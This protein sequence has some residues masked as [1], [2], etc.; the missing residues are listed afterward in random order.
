MVITLEGFGFG[1]AYKIF[2]FLYF[3]KILGVAFYLHIDRTLKTP[4]LR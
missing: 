3:Q 1:T 2:Q 4:M